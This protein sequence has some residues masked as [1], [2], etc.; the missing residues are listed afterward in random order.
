MLHHRASTLL[1]FFVLCSSV[2]M[3]QDNP[4]R[5]GSD[6]PEG[7]GRPGLPAAGQAGPRFG[8]LPIMKALDTDQDGILSAAEIQN[9]SK[10]L[11]TLDKNGD[12]MLSAEEMRPDPSVFARPGQPG[13]DAAPGQSGRPGAGGAPT[14][15]MM[16]R[17]FESRDTNK[18]GKLSGDEIPERMRENIS[19]VDTNG[20]NA[21]DREELQKAMARMAEQAGQQRGNRPGR[22][23]DGGQGVQP[24]RPN[25]E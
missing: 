10:A 12:G 14:G 7:R 17:M 20:D 4:R 3:S 5:P 2:A 16:A 22:G 15:E 24:K 9:A 6:R 19:R 11:A 25:A 23:T 18:D 21:I 1:A 8:M 13:A